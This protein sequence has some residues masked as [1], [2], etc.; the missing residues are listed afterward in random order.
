M[1]IE[2]TYN[3]KTSSK[4]HLLLEQIILRKIERIWNPD[5]RLTLGPSTLLKIANTPEN[6]FLLEPELVAI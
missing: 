4:A 6:K 3:Y 5:N 1:T 2:L